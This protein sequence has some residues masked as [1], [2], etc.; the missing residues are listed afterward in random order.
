MIVKIVEALLWFAAVIVVVLR[1]D[2]LWARLR[3]LR[4]R[5]GQ[6]LD[7][8]ARFFRPEHPFQLAVD[9]LIITHADL[10]HRLLIVPHHGRRSR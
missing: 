4:L 9:R 10:D 1:L 3:E 2:Y 5:V 8:S 7:V 6:I